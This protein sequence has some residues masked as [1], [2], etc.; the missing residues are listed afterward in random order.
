MTLTR[1]DEDITRRVQVVEFR[2]RRS[3]DPTSEPRVLV[4]PDGDPPRHDPRRDD[5]VTR[6]IRRG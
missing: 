6:P 2:P 3:K 1:P 4:R 5:E